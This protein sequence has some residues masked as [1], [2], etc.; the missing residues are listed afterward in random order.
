VTC[1]LRQSGQVLTHKYEGCPRAF[2]FPPLIDGGSRGD[3]PLKARWED[4]GVAVG[5][6][7]GSF[8]DQDPRV[9]TIVALGRIENM[10]WRK[11]FGAVILAFNALVGGEPED[12]PLDGHVPARD[13]VVK[14]MLGATSYAMLK[15]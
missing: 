3:P 4:R 14:P 11:L 5:D 15:G 6:L 2:T 1:A 9:A 8:L 12:A 7:G 13:T 10:N